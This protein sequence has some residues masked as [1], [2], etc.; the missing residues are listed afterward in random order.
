MSRGRARCRSPLSRTGATSRSMSF[1]VSRRRRHTSSLRD[2]S[3]DVCSS[4][5]PFGDLAELRTYLW[6][7][8]RFVHRAEWVVDAA[9]RKR[10]S[11]DQFVIRRAVRYELLEA[12][13]AA[14][15][16]DGA[17]SRTRVV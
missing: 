7:H 5:L 6:E 17:T 3:S 16:R 12:R 4:D 15:P 9:T 10:H 14:S 1:F 11:N 8:L 2:W 13:L